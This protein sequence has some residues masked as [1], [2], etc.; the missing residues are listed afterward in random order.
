VNEERNTLMI[1]VGIDI[2]KQKIDVW[3]N[4]KLTSLEN[5]EKTIKKFFVPIC[6]D[7]VKV[8][9]EA[10]G[11][12]HRTAHS[13]LNA[14]GFDVMVINPF[15]SRH[16]AKSMNIFCKTDKVDAKVLSQYAQRM[17]FCKTP[18][19]S[20]NEEDLQNLIR[21][22]DDL[23]HLLIQHK[24]RL[25]FASGITQKSLK[26]L[27]ES[28]KIE[29]AVTTKAIEALIQSDDN[30]AKRCEILTSIP[31]IGK[32]TAAMLSGLLSELGSISNKEATAL[33]GLAPM[34]CDSGKFT[35][36]RHIQK[37]RHDVRRLLYIPTMGA[38]TMHN[39]VLKNFYKKLIAAGKPP[40]VALVACMRK[41][42]VFANT[43]LKKGEKWFFQPV[44]NELAFSE[45]KVAA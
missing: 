13:V 43:L 35:G 30:L 34:N 5:N 38:A 7:G 26:R 10:T 8:V 11:R 18:V 6:R 21:Y 4:N 37:G 24:N 23:K 31:G 45:T 1:A 15:Q 14:L 19:L 25:E 3:M 16:F 9:M 12:Y 36:K 20:K 44:M 33:A 27:I 41:L 2:S 42:I 29:M 39:S 17:E 22:L 28:T 32:A 40:M